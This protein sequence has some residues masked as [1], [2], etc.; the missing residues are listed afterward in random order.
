RKD[1]PP[2]PEAREERLQFLNQLSVFIPHTRNTP[3]TQADVARLM[4]AVLTVDAEKGAWTFDD[5][6]QLRAAETALREGSVLAEADAFKKQVEQLEEKKR[7]ENEE[8][9]AR[10]RWIDRFWIASGLWAG[11]IAFWGALIFLYPRYRWVQAVFFWN[12]YVRTISGLVYVPWVITLVPFLRR[13]LLEPFQ[14]SLIPYQFLHDF[15][16]ESY[17]AGSRITSRLDGKDVEKTATEYLAPPLSGARVIEAP[18]GFGKT[19]LLQWFVRQPGGPRVL[20]RAVECDE[21]EEGVLKA[22]QKLVQ[23]IAADEKFL[24]TLVYAGGLDVIIDGLNEA[25]P[26]TRVHITK[27][28]NTLF[29]GNY[30]L[31][32]QPL[33]GF[34]VPRAAEVWKL[35]PLA[36]DQ[37]AGFLLQQW[38]RVQPAAATKGVTQEAYE[39]RVRA[40]IKELG[41]PTGPEP[42]GIST[43]LDA[44]LTTDLLAQGVEPDLYNLVAQH[45]L[46][47][48]DTFRASAPAQEP[49][50][51]QIGERARDRIKNGK[52]L[53]LTGL[54]RERDALTHRKLLIN[55]GDQYDFRHD[56][57]RDYFIA[58]AVTD[59]AAALDL[60]DDVRFT[61]VFEFLPETLEPV[62]A[63]ELGEYL[64]SAS[65]DT[66]DKR[67]WEKYRCRWNEPTAAAR[68]EGFITEAT[69]HFHKKNPGES[70]NYRAVGERAE[71][72]VRTGALDWMRLEAEVE[73]LLGAHVFKPGRAAGDA[74]RFRSDEI[75]D[76]L[77]ARSW[78][79]TGALDRARA[80]CADG[81][82]AGVFAFLPALLDKAERDELGRFLEKENKARPLAA[83]G[84]YRKHWRPRKG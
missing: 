44:M 53:D 59:V 57:I 41:Q 39:G 70:P 48:R 66:G 80:C 73:C 29:R 50:F 62:E 74:P 68:I 13:R 40:L 52:A 60:R 82:F 77:I 33:P 22:I 45:V 27:F 54:E 55:H 31:T 1:V 14:G 11:H 79:E 19:T 25:T 49:K 2:L 10:Q 37:V 46:L 17:F 43:P 5:L 26:E 18:S 6:G 75:R 12:P 63:N 20:L 71:A 69:R 7:K 78:A 47:A 23:G 21:G 83:W 56:R 64:K 32:T 8:R 76:Y 15:Q 42:F 36:G 34:K 61:G 67:V 51:G 30:L 35:Q 3:R 9:N 24:R 16:S 28:V 72:A 38:S 58:L 81:R 84:P 65:A 4:H